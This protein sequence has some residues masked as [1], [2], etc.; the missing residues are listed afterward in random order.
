MRAESWGS[1]GIQLCAGLQS[2]AAVQRQWQTVCSRGEK[3]CHGDKEEE[4][5]CGPYAGMMK[6]QM[7]F[8]GADKEFWKAGA[9][10][11]KWC[12]ER[13]TEA[14]IVLAFSLSH[15]YNRIQKASLGMAVESLRFHDVFTMSRLNMAL[16]D[17]LPASKRVRLFLYQTV[18]SRRFAT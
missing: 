17:I 5:G 2:H 16:S 1:L 15:L 3:E 13:H 11:R 14:G 8:S 6:D 7:G 9:K 4:G 18:C 12:G 10:V